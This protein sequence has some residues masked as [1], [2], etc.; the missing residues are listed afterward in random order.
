MISFYI[1][2]KY[3]FSEQK[4]VS[5]F[6]LAVLGFC[7]ACAILIRLNMFPLWL[8]FCAVIFIEAIQERRF[9]AL[10]KYIMGFCVGILIVAVPAFFYLKLNGIFLTAAA[11]NSSPKIFISLLTGLIVRLLLVRVF[12]G[13]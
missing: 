13:A 4:N 12:F 11:S 1:F 10:G 6:E 7:F 2:T 9:A 3:F 5:F 8:G